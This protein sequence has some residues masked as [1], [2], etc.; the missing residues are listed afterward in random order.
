VHAV[1][2]QLLNVF[3][4]RMIH[5]KKSSRQRFMGLSLESM[6][7][8][9]KVHRFSQVLSIFDTSAATWFLAFSVDFTLEFGTK[10]L[11]NHTRF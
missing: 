11:G 10:S 8:R 9:D 2:V 1:G 5:F 6:H 7:E 4:I 3:L